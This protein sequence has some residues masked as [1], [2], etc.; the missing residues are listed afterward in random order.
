MHP[1][2]KWETPAQPYM[3]F[4]PLITPRDLAANSTQAGLGDYSQT[5]ISN[6]RALAEF[7]TGVLPRAHDDLGRAGAVCPFSSGSLRRGMMRLTASRLRH[8]DEGILS[9][10]MSLLRHVFLSKK[11]DDD[12][13][14]VFRSI[15]VVFPHLP[16]VEGARLIDHVQKSLKPSF[17]R[18]GLMIGEFYPDCPAPGLHNAAFRPLQTPV[19]CLSIRHMTVFDAPFMID[20]DQHLALFLD[21]Y[22]GGGEHQVRNS[23]ASRNCPRTSARVQAIVASQAQ[24]FEVRT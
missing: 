16:V 8:I 17:V 12:P 5:E 15:T 19:V 7:M 14:E 9:D 24:A 4:G 10:A 21:R 18:S 20:D 3:M 23:V 22:G 2:E 6:L 13:E 11:I 1:D